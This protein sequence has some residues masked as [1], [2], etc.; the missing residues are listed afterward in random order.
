MQAAAAD[1]N[2]EANILPILVL[3]LSWRGAGKPGFAGF[4][5]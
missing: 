2:G 5:G 1:A 3:E 4:G